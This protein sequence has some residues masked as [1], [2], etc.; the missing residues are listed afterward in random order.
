MSLGIAAVNRGYKAVFSH[1]DQL[2]HALKTQEISPRSRKKIQRLYQSDLVIIDEVGFHPANR[3]EANLLFGV[4]NQLYQ[5]TS[6]IITSN[7]G[8]IEWEEF[9]GD[10]VITAAIRNG[11]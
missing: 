1:M 7:K 8:L 10:P 3:S 4:V 9:M 6:I 11:Q 5:Q 2:I